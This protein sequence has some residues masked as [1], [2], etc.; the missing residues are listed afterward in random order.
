MLYTRCPFREIEILGDIKDIS[1]IERTL[2][3]AQQPRVPTTNGGVPEDWRDDT[4]SVAKAQLPPTPTKS[5][6]SVE[7]HD[8]RSLTHAE[9]P[10]LEAVS[11]D[12]DG[13]VQD[14][15]VRTRALCD[16]P[17]GGRAESRGELEE[18]HLVGGQLTQL[19]DNLLSI[20]DVEPHLVG[21]TEGTS[22]DVHTTLIH[23]GESECG[24]VDTSGIEDGHEE[25]LASRL[26][27]LVT[28]ELVSTSPV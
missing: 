17:T 14:A 26:V 25:R 11:T 4:A 12:G 3:V 7:T 19:G 6:L 9:L 15:L 1:L 23:G 28:S 8:T 18:Q 21:T 5:Q 27:S 10:S 24:R 22:R 13:L 16:L 20:C 2:V